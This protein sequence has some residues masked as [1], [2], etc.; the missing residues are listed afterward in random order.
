MVIRK[1]DWITDFNLINEWLNVRDLDPVDHPDLPEIGFVCEGVVPI[2]AA[3][4][5]RCE[6]DYAIF[7]SLISNPKLEGAIRNEAIDLLVDEI[8]KKAQDMGIKQLFAYSV[9]DRTLERAFRHGFVKL[10]HSIIAMRVD[11]RFPH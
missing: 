10:P 9:D 2:A 5:R 8:V 7:D 11:H 3:F 1:F 6:G 4:I